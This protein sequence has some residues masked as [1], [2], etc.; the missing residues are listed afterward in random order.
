LNK[1][2]LLNTIEA[3]DQL[4]SAMLDHNLNRPHFSEISDALPLS[5]IEDKWEMYVSM[6]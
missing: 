1:A 6:L 3:L 4:M 2:E 5:E